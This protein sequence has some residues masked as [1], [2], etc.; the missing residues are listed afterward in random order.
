[1]GSGTRDSSA[2]MERRI[3]KYMGYSNGGGVEVDWAGGLWEPGVRARG[4]RG[5]ER[6]YVP[7]FEQAPALTSHAEAHAH[8]LRQPYT[9]ASPYFVIHAREFQRLVTHAC[10][11]LSIPSAMRASAPCRAPRAWTR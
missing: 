10:V 4:L 11:H 9:R 1:M 7:M 2:E 6:T 3:L 5:R 8:A